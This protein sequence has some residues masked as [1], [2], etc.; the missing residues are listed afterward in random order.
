MPFPE[1]LEITDLKPC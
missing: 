1:I